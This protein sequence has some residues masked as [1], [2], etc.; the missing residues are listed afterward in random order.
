MSPVAGGLLAE[1]DRPDVVSVCLSAYVCVC[2]EWG[3]LAAAGDG[4]RAGA[5]GLAKR[6]LPKE[7]ACSSG[8]RQDMALWLRYPHLA[9][10]ACCEFLGMESFGMHVRT[11]TW[12]MPLLIAV[13]AGDWLLLR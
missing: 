10:W 12:S 7:L 11:W 4:A 9:H 13:V 2:V 1:N 8:C 5:D 6:R 3:S